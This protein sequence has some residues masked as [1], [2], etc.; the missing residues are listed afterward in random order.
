MQHWHSVLRRP[1]DSTRSLEENDKALEKV[2]ALEHALEVKATEESVL[3][4]DS[5]KSSRRGQMM[6]LNLKWTLKL[7]WQ[8]CIVMRTEVEW[9][10]QRLLML[11][12]SL[13]L[14][15]PLRTNLTRKDLLPVDSREEAA[16]SEIEF[17]LNFRT[18]SRKLISHLEWKLIWTIKW[19]NLSHQISSRNQRT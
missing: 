4:L 8:L 12:W 16:I 15:L 1:G 18:I 13:L 2:E 11:V 10:P 5:L 3:F 19:H 6:S 14:S 9:S 7:S 17:S